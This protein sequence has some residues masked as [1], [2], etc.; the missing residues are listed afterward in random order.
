M[1]WHLKNE[2]EVENANVIWS[3]KQTSSEHNR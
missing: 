2:K 3:E 1:I